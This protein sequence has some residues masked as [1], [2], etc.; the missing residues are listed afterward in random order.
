MAAI[1][2]LLGRVSDPALRADL[3]RELAP[4]RK[5]HEFGLVF[6]RHLPETVRLPQHPVRRGVRVQERGAAA[7]GPVWTV[8]RARAGTAVL[9]RVDETGERL[10][11]TLPTSELVVVREFG[12]AIFPGLRSLGGLREGGGKPCHVVIKGENYHA[13]ETLLY[14][15]SEAVD[16]IYIDPPY[17]LGGDL[18]YNDHRVGREDSFRHSKWLSFMDRRLR[19]ARGLLRQS[20]TI[21]VAI[22]DTEH[23]YLRVLMDQI[24][25]EQN[26]IANVVWQG[27]VKNDARFIGGGIDYML[28][29]ARNKAELTKLDVR[30]RE[31]KE[32][33]QDVLDEGARCWEKHRP[34]HLAATK[35]LSS[36]WS[37]NKHRYDPGLGDNVKID[38]DGTVIKVG[39]LSWPGGGGPKYDVLHPVTGQPVVPPSAGWRFT[40]QRMQELIAADR[41]LFGADHR[42]GA[43]SK[44]PLAEM[45]E[46]VIKPSFGKERRAS[47]KMLADLMGEKTFDFPKDPT[48]LARWIGIVSG[49]NPDAVV[50]DFFAGSGSTAHAVML[51][52]ERDGGRRQSI[53]VTNNEV[54]ES[55]ARAM[56]KK[57]LAP[58]DGEWEAAGV[59]HRS[60]KP[61]L[62]AVISGRRPDGSQHRQGSKAENIEFLELTYLDRDR[63]QLGTAYEA[64]APLL[65]LRAGA[66]GP[67][68]DSV[69]GGWAL[70]PG[71]ACGVLLDCDRWPE[72]ARAAAAAGGTVSHAFV[73]TGSETVFQQVAAELPAQVRPVRL[74]GDYL[75][76]FAINTGGRA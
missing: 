64:V 68:I 14:T 51:L 29:Y 43:R 54:T 49:G 17:N 67:R 45:E 53:L 27:S 47:A 56:G 57:G 32:G 7:D 31:P 6:E 71:T 61:R 70:P 59:F 42:S 13:L 2:D 58:G 37:R 40:E 55:D 28:I 48:V 23:A 22:D 15:H 21:I 10:E 52:N 34:D 24:F 75:D 1:D 20:G 26:F 18:T 30:W 66:R 4:L 46:Q 69:Q 63:V 65:W 60:T 36:W 73:V 12:E 76:A 41:I 3:E 39:N 72:F 5:E 74:Y 9:E 35:A 25:G 11:A 62:E 44:T 16:V 8:V 19:M 33:L 50:L 38:T